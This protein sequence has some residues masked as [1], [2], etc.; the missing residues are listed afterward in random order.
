MNKGTKTPSHRQI[1]AI[2]LW[3]EGGCKSKAQAILGAGYGKSIAHQPHK[4]FDSP[5]VWEELAKRGYAPNGTRSPVQAFNLGDEISQPEQPQVDFSKMSREWLQELKSRLEE[6]PE[7]PDLFK[8]KEEIVSI[9]STT[10]SLG[11]YYAEQQRDISM[12][13]M[14]SM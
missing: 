8:R 3:L 2:D 12:K 5:A 4:V 7:F 13:D 14:S 10:A 9:A 1:R 6:I 11:D